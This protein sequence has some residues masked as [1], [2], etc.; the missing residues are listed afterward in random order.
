MLNLQE[1]QM[2]EMI[3][4]V[5]HY[6]T[7]TTLQCFYGLKTLIKILTFEILLIISGNTI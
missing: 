4:D 1:M 2:I 5:C 7:V 6:V 3:S